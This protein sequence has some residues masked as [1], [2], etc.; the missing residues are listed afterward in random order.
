MVR[1][2]SSREGGSAMTMGGFEGSEC[3][4]A[5]ERALVPLVDSATGHRFHGRL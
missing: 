3:T 4:E 1:G 2:E 5:L